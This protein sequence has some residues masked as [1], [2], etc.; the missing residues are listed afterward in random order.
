MGFREELPS[1]CPPTGAHEG[2]CAEAYRLLSSSAPDAQAFASHA[3]SQKPLPLGM[4]ACRWASCSL[5]SDLKTII[6]KRKLPGRKKYTY[7]ALLKIDAGSGRILQ[8]GPHID[9]WMFDTFDPL[10]AIVH[11]RPV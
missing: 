11:V 3:A 1:G 9:F 4:D 6:K 7:V 10:E 8:N 2:E 5:Y